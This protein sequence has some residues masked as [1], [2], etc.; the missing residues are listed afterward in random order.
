MGRTPNLGTPKKRKGECGRG[1]AKR[2]KMTP[3]PPWTQNWHVGEEEG[4]KQ[5]AS[6]W[7]SVPRDMLIIQDVSSPSADCPV[8]YLESFFV[9]LV[10]FFF[11]NNASE[12]QRQSEFNVGFVKKDIHPAP[13]KTWESV[14]T[15]PCL[16][17]LA[18]EAQN[19]EWQVWVSHYHSLESLSSGN[20]ISSLASALLFTWSGWEDEALN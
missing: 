13:S 4:G 3:L 16:L 20:R 19:L 10:F 18:P 6:I 1:D 11:K 5:T 2:T 8:H 7:V 12:A 15:E 14:A 17:Y 9:F